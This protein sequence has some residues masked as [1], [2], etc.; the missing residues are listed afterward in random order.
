MFEPSRQIHPK[1]VIGVRKGHLDLWKMHAFFL[2]K[3]TGNVDSKRYNS[4]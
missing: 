1:Q 4:M 3:V 2:V